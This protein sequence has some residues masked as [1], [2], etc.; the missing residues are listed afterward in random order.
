MFRDVQMV[1]ACGVLGRA[2]CYVMWRIECSRIE[3]GG[4]REDVETFRLLTDFRK[5]SFLL[6][7]T[8]ELC[9]L[10]RSGGRQKIPLRWGFTVLNP[11]RRRRNITLEM[12]DGRP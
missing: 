12:L 3:N 11:S 5:Y 2:I 8:F 4:W 9:A 7:T 6:V 1:L 10:C